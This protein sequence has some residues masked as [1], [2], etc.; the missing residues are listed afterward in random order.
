MKKLKVLCLPWSN[1]LAHITRV[2][3]LAEE[4]RARGHEVVFGVSKSKVDLIEKAGFTCEQT[5]ETPTEEF[6]EF[7]SKKEIDPQT[8]K[9]IEQFIQEDLE[10]IN[11]HQPDVVI[12]DMKFSTGLAC[13]QKKVFWVTIVNAIYLPQ[14]IGS[15]CVELFNPWFVN[16][17]SSLVARLVLSYHKK[18][19]N[20]LVENLGQKDKYQKASVYEIFNA[21][22][23]ILADVPGF[24]PLKNLLENTHYVGP[25]LWDEFRGVPMEEVK[26]FKGDKPL[27][28]VS[29]GATVHQ[30]A[31]I[32]SAIEALKDSLY[33][34]VVTMGRVFPELEDKVP[35]NFLVKKYLPGGEVCA[36]ADMMINHGG[37]SSI[38]QA[39]EAGIPSITIPH[40]YSQLYYAMRVN[41]LKL[42]KNLLKPSI[43][44]FKKDKILRKVLTM[45]T[46][47]FG[48]QQIS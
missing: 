42:G 12:S 30:R 9:M 36:M 27:V 2:L 41:R 40:N 47:P 29:S 5:T 34:V 37:H 7:I 39:F 15:P 38:M 1:G 10:L 32:E 19:I 46:A 21:D 33:R 28:Y 3:S 22:L 23:K 13:R 35:D 6:L 25:L 16:K 18:K 48:G 20:S 4:L 14:F 8:A 43:S 31:M 24:S 11:K 17:F 45:P 26:R 44:C